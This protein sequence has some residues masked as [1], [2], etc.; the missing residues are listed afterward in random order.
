MERVMMIPLIKSFLLSTKME[1]KEGKE[2]AWK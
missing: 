2:K 1:A